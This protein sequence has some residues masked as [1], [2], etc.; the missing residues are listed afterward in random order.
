MHTTTTPPSIHRWRQRIPP[1]YYVIHG[2][3]CCV[4]LDAATA[5]ATGSPRHHPRLGL[6]RDLERGRVVEVRIP[7]GP[8]QRHG[9][10]QPGEGRGRGRLQTLHRLDSSGVRRGVPRPGLHQTSLWPKTRGRMHKGLLKA[11]Q[12]VG[13]GASVSVPLLCGH[14]REK[15]AWVREVLAEAGAAQRLPFSPRPHLDH[16]A[17]HRALASFDVR[18]VCG[19][20]PLHRLWHIPAKDQLL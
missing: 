2:Q 10:V 14:L 8:Q 6:L 13:A 17:S 5:T 20:E 16:Q 9:R 12:I 18:E 4:I 11:R 7:L 3:A 15:A 19:A 1:T